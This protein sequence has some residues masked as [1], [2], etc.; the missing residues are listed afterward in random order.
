M[1]APAQKDRSP[2]PVIIMTFILSSTPTISIV[3]DNSAITS[4]FIAFSASGLLILIVAIPPCGSSW[5]Y[6][7]LDIKEKQV[8]LS[9]KSYLIA[10]CTLSVIMHQVYINS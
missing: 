10:A 1:S 3:L 5:M 2:A 6:F 8:Y 9:I 7:I 4:V